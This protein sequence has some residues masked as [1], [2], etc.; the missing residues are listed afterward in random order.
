MNYILILTFAKYF[1]P[2]GLTEST[3]IIII[4]MFILFMQILLNALKKPKASNLSFPQVSIVA[5]SSATV[6]IVP[7]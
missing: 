4:G 3:G 2:E 6:F 1:L 7:K 5:C